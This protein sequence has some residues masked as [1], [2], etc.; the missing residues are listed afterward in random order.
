MVRDNDLVAIFHSIHRV[1]KAEKA[2]KQERVDILL[3]PVPRQL[4]SDC[5][6]AIRYPEQERNRVLLVLLREDLLPAELYSYTGKEF[7]RVEF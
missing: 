7:R 3:I 1:M 6:L 2:L 5:G 4:T